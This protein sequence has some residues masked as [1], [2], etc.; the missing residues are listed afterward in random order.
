MRTGIIKFYLE[1]KGYGYIRDPKTREEFH[2]RRQH[3]K[4]PVA[5]GEHVR[6][7]VAEGKQGQYAVEV[8]KI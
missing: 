4:T 2:V 8:E 5:K 1:E 6:F 3:L 7:K